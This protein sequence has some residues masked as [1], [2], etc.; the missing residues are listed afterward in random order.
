MD[1]PDV[2]CCTHMEHR[3]VLFTVPNVQ[4]KEKVKS[5]ALNHNSLMASGTMET[6]A[7]SCKLPFSWSVVYFWFPDMK[8]T[9]VSSP[10]PLVYL[11]SDFSGTPIFIHTQTLDPRLCSAHCPPHS[12]SFVTSWC[13]CSNHK[14]EILI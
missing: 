3:Y 7:S 14:S 12:A 13:L 11:A 6:S 5:A 9:L 2:N 1:E 4:V 8:V 10:S